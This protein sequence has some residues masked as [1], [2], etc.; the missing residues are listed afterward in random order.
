M[1]N[2]QTWLKGLLAA[3][4]SGGSGGI[5]TYVGTTVFTPTL[6]DKLDS[7]DKISF[8]GIVALVSAILGACNYLKQSPLP[9]GTPK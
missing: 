1:G 8:L 9:N 6:M 2:W 3:V 7:A 4:I 5:L